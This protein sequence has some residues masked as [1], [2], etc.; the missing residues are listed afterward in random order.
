VRIGAA[1]I[2]GLVGAILFE[3]GKWG[4]TIGSAY[5]L[6]SYN[7]IYTGIAALFIFLFWLNLCWLIVL[8]GLEVTLATQTATAYAMDELAARVNHRGRELVALRIATE[9]ACRFGRGNDPPT[10]DVLAKAL[11]APLRLV[12]DVL[13]LLEEAGL[14]RA[15]EVGKDELGYVAGRP[16]DKVSLADVS[17]VLRE[18]DGVPLTLCKDDDTTYLESL[19]AEAEV[20]VRGIYGRESLKGVAE[21]MPACPSAGVAARDGNGDAAP[22]PVDPAPV[23]GASAA[24]APA[25]APGDG[26]IASD[27]ESKVERAEP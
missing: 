12:H 5:L 11:H 2:G 4:F 24:R 1:I 15:V 27:V 21:R 10:A 13:G 20:A 16:L 3:L 6:A 26:P 22:C 14:V 18:R 8:V 17:A 19:L 7:R 25:E 9:V 23:E